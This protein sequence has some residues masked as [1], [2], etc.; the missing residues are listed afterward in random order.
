MWSAQDNILFASDIKSIARD[1]MLTTQDSG[2]N[3]QDNMLSARNII[4]LT[5]QIFKWTEKRCPKHTTLF[6]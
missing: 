1:D 6:I 3:T 4:C 5:L 2:S